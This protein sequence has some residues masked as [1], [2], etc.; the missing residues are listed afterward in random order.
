MNIKKAVLDIYLA[1]FRREQLPDY[2]PR[3]STINGLE[4][5]FL[6]KVVKRKLEAMNIDIIIPSEAMMILIICA[7]NPGYIQLMIKEILTEVMTYNNGSI[8][9]GYAITTT[10]FNMTYG[11]RIPITSEYPD[12]SHEYKKKWDAQKIDTKFGST[13]AVDTIDWWNEIKFDN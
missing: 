11:D 9:R 4:D 5:E 1:W 8:P 6:F 13:N 10:D 7:D 2:D 3:V 12:I